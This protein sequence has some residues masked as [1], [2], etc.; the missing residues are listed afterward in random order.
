MCTVTFIP[1]ANNDFIFTSS[2]DVPFARK[3]AL[4]PKKY[5]EDKVELLYPKD[6]NAGG[7]WIGTSDK[8]RL[9]CLLNGGF[10]NHTHKGS[11]RQSRGL[12]VKEILKS[13]T[14][15]FA[16]QLVD[17]NDI[18]PFTIV[19]LDWNDGLDL[20][21]LVWDGKK[22]HIQKL[23]LQPKIWSS[24]TLYSDEVKKWRELWFAEWQKKQ[25]FYAS[26]ILEFHHIAGIGDP[27]IDVLMRR[28]KGGTVSITQVVKKGDKIDMYYEPIKLTVG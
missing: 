4:A 6:G 10:K 5:I 17:L 13:N 15:N 12:I 20:V 27:E 2:R 25:K 21:E 28:E 11:Y 22:K 19:A 24:S 1:L 8:N 23:L 16:L 26:S 3:P 7:S 9:I 14:L 18:E